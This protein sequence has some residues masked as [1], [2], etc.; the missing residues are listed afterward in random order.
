MARSPFGIS[1]PPLDARSRRASPHGACGHATDSIRWCARLKSSVAMKKG[2]RRS[3]QLNPSSSGFSPP[4]VRPPAPRRHGPS[5]AGH[6]PAPAG[7]DRRAQ[8]RSSAEGARAAGFTHEPAPD[9]PVAPG[10]GGIGP[11][12]RQH[13]AVFGELCA[14]RALI[15]QRTN[16]VGTASSDAFVPRWDAQERSKTDHFRSAR[17]AA[18]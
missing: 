4:A 9:M 14:G 1:T 2:S 16:P 8:S 18:A 7:A 10:R 12:V 5:Q 17:S 11:L 6:I 15:A 13:T 3:C